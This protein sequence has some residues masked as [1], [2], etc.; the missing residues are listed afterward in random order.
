MP[1]TEKEI[2]GISIDQIIATLSKVPFIGKRLVHAAIDRSSQSAKCDN[3]D[4]VAQLSV[5]DIVKHPLTI[6]SQMGFKRHARVVIASVPEHL[7]NHENS[8]SSPAAQ[9]SSLADQKSE[10]EIKAAEALLAKELALNT[11]Q[12]HHYTTE[13]HNPSS[14]ALQGA[15]ASSVSKTT[16]KIVT[17]FH[18]DQCQKGRLGIHCFKGDATDGNKQQLV[19]RIKNILQA[20]PDVVEATINAEN[21]KAFTLEDVFWVD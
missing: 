1:H 19:D 6:L 12:Q 18:C 10:A 16:N 2:F 13:V 3:C 4:N 9:S 20:M 11:N 15:L 7:N 21:V 5:A 8:S 14:P 17:A